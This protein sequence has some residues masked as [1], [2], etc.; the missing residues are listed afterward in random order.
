MVITSKQISPGTT[1]SLDGKIYRVET[2]LKVTVARGVPFIK[3][4]LK[5][6]MS[7][8]V[9]EKNFKLDQAIEEVTLSERFLEFLYLEGKDY[10]FLDI[11]E[12]D[13]ILVPADIVADK[14]NY[15]KEGIQIKA[16][17]YGETIFSIELPQFLELMII[18]LE[19]IKSKISVSS[20][21]KIAILETGA[22]VEVPLF[23]E[24]GDII[25]VDTHL[26]EYVQRI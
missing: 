23:I 5:N 15:L 4:K 1:L 22:K 8:E 21:S 3:T 19:D 17:F 10:F 16:M 2:S 11:N 18:K 9:I 24:V 7:D 25:N 13:E 14:V 20:A 12:L 6:L 26:G